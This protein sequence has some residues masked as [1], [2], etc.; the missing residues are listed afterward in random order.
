MISAIAAA[1]FVKASVS[2]SRFNRGQ[3]GKVFQEA[4]RDGIKIVFKNNQPECILLS[5]QVFEEIKEALEDL[6]LFAE[7]EERLKEACDSDFISAEE[8]MKELGIT[9]AE[10]KTKT[11]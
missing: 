5:P 11:I 3:A 2:I 6:R 10:L 4:K 7:A 9:E 8:V 1:D